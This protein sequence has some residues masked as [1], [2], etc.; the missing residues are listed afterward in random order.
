MHYRLLM[1]AEQTLELKPDDAPEMFIL[2]AFD[3]LDHAPHFQDWWIL[4]IMA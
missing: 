2:G 3:S 1:Y 4:P